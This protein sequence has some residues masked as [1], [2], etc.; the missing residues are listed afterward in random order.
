M[1]QGLLCPPRGESPVSPLSNGCHPT[2]VWCILLYGV[3]Y[4]GHPS[5][6]IFGSYH[7]CYSSVNYVS[8]LVHPPRGEGLVC[9][10][11]NGGLVGPPIVSII[12]IP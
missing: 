1:G 10:P 3:Y 12:I 9:P 2:I 5:P 4:C 7:H 6:T 11:S 8:G